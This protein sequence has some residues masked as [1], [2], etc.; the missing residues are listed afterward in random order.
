MIYTR[1]IILCLD[2]YRAAKLNIYFIISK[3]FSQN[4]AFVKTKFLKSQ[5]Y[6]VIAIC[7]GWSDWCNVFS[8]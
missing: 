4:H 6:S 8:F 5:I 3:L 7:F 1:K 2:E